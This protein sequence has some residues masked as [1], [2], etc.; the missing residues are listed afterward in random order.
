MS[1]FGGHD[2]IVDAQTALEL[3]MLKFENGPRFGKT[4]GAPVTLLLAVQNKTLACG[5]LAFSK[6]WSEGHRSKYNVTKVHS[7]A[8]L[9]QPVRASAAQQMI[10]NQISD[11][12]S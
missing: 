10:T 1:R 4:L 5:K 6:L 3:A 7:T 9:M 8:D 2:S 11:L 12:F